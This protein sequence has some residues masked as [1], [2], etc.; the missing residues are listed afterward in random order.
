MREKFISG[1]GSEP[2]VPA[3]YS[4]VLPPSFSGTYHTADPN[5]SLYIPYTPGRVKQSFYYFYEG[6]PTHDDFIKDI[7]ILNFN[8]STDRHFYSTD[9]H[10]KELS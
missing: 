10:M 8:L 2:Q 6:T 1:P 5:L 4:D 9:I 7:F 3:L